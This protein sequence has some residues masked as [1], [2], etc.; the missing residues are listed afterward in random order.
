MKQIISY[1][2]F[3]LIILASLSKIN[4]QQEK[5]N[6]KIE[7]NGFDN[8]DGVARILLF[9]TEEKDAFPS[10]QNLALLKKIVHIKNKKVVFEFSDLPYGEY[11]VSIHHDEN[12]DGKVNT[13]F[14][15]IPNEGLGCTNDAKGFFGPPSFEKAKVKLNMKELHVIINVVN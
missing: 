13:N 9:S 3:F 10:K 6:I 11:A 14:L 8:D 5:E 1:L 2:F 12:A 7:V 4:A 15:G